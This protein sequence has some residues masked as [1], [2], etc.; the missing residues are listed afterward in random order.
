MLYALKIRM[1]TEL[2]NVVYFFR[3]GSHSGAPSDIQLTQVSA[4]SAALFQILTQLSLEKHNLSVKIRTK[5]AQ[6]KA[7]TRIL[8]DDIRQHEHLA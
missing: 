6:N 5:I 1:G 8:L 3:K 4:T 2:F 7:Q